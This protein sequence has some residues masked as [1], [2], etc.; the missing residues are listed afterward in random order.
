MKRAILLQIS[1][2]KSKGNTLRKSLLIATSEFNR[3]WDGRDFCNT[4]VNSDRQASPDIA[5][6]FLLERR[7]TTDHNTLQISNRGSL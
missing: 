6:K 1:S 3:L 2:A 7:D 5:I 4:V